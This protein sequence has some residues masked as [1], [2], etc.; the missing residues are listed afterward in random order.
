MENG[1]NIV[2]G[3]CFDFASHLT[4]LDDPIQVGKD[5]EPS[6]TIDALADWA[7]VRGLDASDPLIRSWREVINDKAKS[8]VDLERLA[9]WL[10]EHMEDQAARAG[11][12]EGPVDIVIRI[13]NNLIVNLKDAHKRSDRSSPGTEEG[14]YARGYYD[15]LNQLR[16]Y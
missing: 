15:A 2:A 12:G 5:F 14:L 1:H 7:S 11:V 3:A 8:E 4:Q 6:A 13:F 16:M 9:T 10:S